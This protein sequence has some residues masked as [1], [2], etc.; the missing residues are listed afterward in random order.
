[1]NATPITFSTISE[2][3]SGFPPDRMWSVVDRLPS[4]FETG[5][6]KEIEHRLDVERQDAGYIDDPI[7]DYLPAPRNLQ[8]RGSE[9]SKPV[10]FQ[11]SRA[12][13]YAFDPDP[14][15]TISASIYIE[16]LTGRVVGRDG[17]VRCPFHDDSTPSLHAYNDP[18]R[19]W[20]C[21]GCH[22]NG[23]IIDFGS[24]L[25]GIEPRGAGFHEIRR[26]L[27]ADLLA[28]AA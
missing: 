10:T 25:Y 20:R 26:R 22:A 8:I 12:P 11:G 13:G 1:V 19:G 23:S 17:K 21:F 3:F 5:A 4:G 9:G 6:W 7:L 15:R 27:A 18:A 16:I 14:L 2:I 24:L 28:E